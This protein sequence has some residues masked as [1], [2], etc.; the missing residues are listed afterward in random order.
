MKIFITM[1]RHP[2]TETFLTPD[3]R[4]RLK[5]AGEVE[6]NPY[7][8]NLTAE[9]LIRLGVDAEV[10][11]TGW[12]TCRLTR[13]VIEKMHALRLIAH[14]GGSV[15]LLADPDIY[16]V[17]GLRVISGNDIYA[18]SVA[19]GC[20][21]YTLGAL[22]RI[23]HYAADMKNGGWMAGGFVNRGLIGKRVGIVGFGA[24]ARYFLEAIR[25]FCCEVLICS[26]HLSEEEAAAYGGRKAGLDEIFSTCDVVSL[27]MSLTQKTEGSIGRDLLMKLKPDALFVNTA[28]GKLVDEKA[29][30]ELL[31]QGRFY[32]ALDVYEN[33]PLDADSPLR[34]CEHALL[35][36]HMAGPTVDMREVV[37]RELTADIKRLT[38]GEALRYEITAEQAGRM[39][40]G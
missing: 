10:L 15:A 28:R 8:R 29:L 27:H 31:G 2:L 21:C 7:D 17:P 6:Q 18:R 37:A 30:A 16:D 14:T 12:G 1:P 32:A 39:S 26:S 13:Q 5:Q 35:M 11:V 22:R 3:V 4:E 9:E 40:R 24:I 33:E 23:G 19:E 25:W 34:A 20:L 36:P 38:G